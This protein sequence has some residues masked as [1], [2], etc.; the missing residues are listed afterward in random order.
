MTSK[1]GYRIVISR[2]LVLSATACTFALGC[3]TPLNAQLP[4]TSLES[5]VANGSIRTTSE[6]AELYASSIAYLLQVVEG[7]IN[8]D[9]GSSIIEALRR[10][11]TD[12]LPS[13]QP[14]ISALLDA[15][16]VQAMVIDADPSES[17]QDERIL[18][19]VND[20][21]MRQN[22]NRSDIE[23]EARRNEY[24]SIMRIQNGEVIG[25]EGRFQLPNDMPGGVPVAAI[26]AFIGVSGNDKV[27]SSGTGSKEVRVIACGAGFYGTGRV[28]E[29]DISRTTNLGGNV[30]DVTEADT[31]RTLISES[32][33]PEYSQPTRFFDVC[34]T[35][36]GSIG[37]ALFEADQYV[38][39]SRTN[40]FETEIW[41]DRTNA[42]RI[43]DAECIAGNRMSDTQDFLVNG[44][45]Q[46]AAELNLKSNTSQSDIGNGVN[47]VPAQ[48][49]ADDGTARPV[50]GIPF[51]ATSTSDFQYARSCMEEYAPAV[52]PSG[53]TGPENFTGTVF[54]YRD[55]NRRETYFSDNP[56][57]YILNY[58]LVRDP[59]SYGYPPK[60]RGPISSPRGTFVAPGDGWYKY[61]ETCTRDLTHPEEETRQTR[62]D[63]TYPAFPNGSVD[64]RREGVGDY[65]QT[66]DDNPSANGP[67]LESIAWG[68]WSETTNRCSATTVTRTQETRTVRRTSGNQRCDQP[69]QR[70]RVET[71][72]DY[73]TGGSYTATSYDPDWENNGG[74]RNCSRISSNNGERNGMSEQ[75]FGSDAQDSYGGGGS[76]G[77]GGGNGGGGGSG[78]SGGDGGGPP[79]R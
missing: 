71:R 72:T 2:K 41:V 54:S 66:T 78:G 29:Y 8:T 6:T 76:G 11:E 53:Y 26:G 64:E 17:A 35:S 43:D 61:T 44:R 37:Q 79:A 27:T 70:T 28:Y 55:F 74:T 10:G 12:A 21:D 22:V 42:T 68:P 46:A 4:T 69:Q 24:V 31:G 20:D 5:L 32:C 47:S 73:Q 3:M 50:D 15:L 58:E 30:Q 1:E 16:G 23:T 14:E 9:P 48:V 13:L 57:E 75:G 39:Q 60:D 25:A 67:T 56:V 45:T 18:V 52:A 49:D 36:D 38:R 59:N 34:T 40:P 33:A 65:I 51:L 63:A 77:G 7:D 19:F 62:C